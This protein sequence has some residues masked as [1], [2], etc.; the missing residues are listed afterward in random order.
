[1]GLHLPPEIEARI[2]AASTPP[3]RVALPI[4]P[5][6]MSEKD[7]QAQ[8]LSLAK[9]LGYLCYHT[10]DSRRSES[11]YPD[12]TLCSPNAVIFAELK[13]ED[14][15][16]SGSQ[17]GWIERLQASGQLVFVWRPSQFSEVQKTLEE[18]R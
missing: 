6:E 9:L 11:G 17:V 4:S 13:S 8:V 16:L 1:M 14:G 3:V 2:L 10:H 5:G 15:V 12:L 7:W 18:H